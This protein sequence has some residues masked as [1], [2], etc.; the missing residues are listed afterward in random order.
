MCHWLRITG[1]VVLAWCNWTGSS[2]MASNSGQICGICCNALR[3]E[4][5]GGS[6]EGNIWMMGSKEKSFAKDPTVSC[7]IKHQWAWLHYIISADH[8]DLWYIL[9]VFELTRMSYISGGIK[10]RHSC[11]HINHI[12]LFFFICNH[13]YL[14]SLISLFAQ[15]SEY[16]ITVQALFSQDWIW[17]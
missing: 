8:T 16:G 6:T 17:I 7:P 5:F 14:Q 10:G 3:I 9:N 2:P 11:L 4:L 1:R 15:A 12:D 13:Y